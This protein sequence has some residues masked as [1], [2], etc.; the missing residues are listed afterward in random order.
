MP[1]IPPG[2]LSWCQT[3]LRKVKHWLVHELATA[4]VLTKCAF[5]TP[6][7]PVEGE[8]VA[9]PAKQMTMI[10]FSLILHLCYSTTPSHMK[11]SRIGLCKV[12]KT[13]SKHL[14][15][16]TDSRK[17]RKPIS[18]WNHENPSRH[19]SCEKLGWAGKSAVG[20]LDNSTSWCIVL[21]RYLHEVK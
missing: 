19:Y 6:R 7:H 1:S 10:A 16:G 12:N 11:N 3:C 4:V 21:K 15:C 14:L 20:P 8:Y 17:Q 13:W 2:S 18:T 5:K 9:Y